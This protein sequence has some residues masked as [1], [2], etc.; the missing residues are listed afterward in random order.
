MV[1]RRATKTGY[2]SRVRATRH[3]LRYRQERQPRL[4]QTC[5]VVT[6][7]QANQRLPYGICWYI[8]RPE[9]TDENQHRQRKD[10]NPLFIIDEML[11]CGVEMHSWLCPPNGF[12]A[13][14]VSQSLGTS[15]EVGQIGRLV[16]LSI[17]QHQLAGRTPDVFWQLSTWKSMTHRRRCG[18]AGGWSRQRVE[19]A[20]AKAGFA[21]RL[22]SSI[23]QLGWNVW[24]SAAC[25]R[26]ALH[27]RRRA[28]LGEALVSFATYSRPRGAPSVESTGRR[29]WWGRHVPK[30]ASA[31]AWTANLATVNSKTY[32]S[33]CRQR[34]GW[35]AR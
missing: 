21:A 30:S 7:D 26:L 35:V 34:Q 6:T 12:L 17:F 11:I 14:N 24:A 23:R 20:L 16:S 28:R 13:A 1:R 8:M 18:K 27:R 2:C 19:P 29:N 22:G 5:D 15:R 9:S 10:D 4:E 3:R 32:Q 33:R 31:A 25:R